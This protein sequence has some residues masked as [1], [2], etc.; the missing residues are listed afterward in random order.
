[1]VAG[2]CQVHNGFDGGVKRFKREHHAN[3]HD[4]GKPRR[5]VDA[6]RE[7]ECD[8]NNGEAGVDAQVALAAH[9][10]G[11]AASCVCERRAKLVALALPFRV[12]RAHE[13]LRFIGGHGLTAV[14]GFEDLVLKRFHDL[15]FLFHDV[16]VAAQ[17]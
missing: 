1:M 5:R 14:P 11:K 13:R 16:V 12:G 8:G 2:A 9:G 3:A 4:D 17:V 7:A 6:Q 15:G 10:F